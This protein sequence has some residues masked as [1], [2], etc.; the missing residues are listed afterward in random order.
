MSSTQL[1][2]DDEGKRVVSSAGDKVGMITEV[3]D[4]TAYVDPDP[5]M[6][7]SIKSKLDWGDMNEDTHPISAEHIAEVT[8]DEVRLR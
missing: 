1:T 6:F 8:D 7:D 5:S 3:S 2:P 4:G